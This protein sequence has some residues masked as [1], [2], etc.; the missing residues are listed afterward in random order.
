MANNTENIGGEKVM[1]NLPLNFPV[2]YLCAIKGRSALKQ[3]DIMN[4]LFRGNYS[5]DCIENVILESTGSGYISGRRKISVNTIVDLCRCDRSELERRFREIVPDFDD[6]VVNLKRLLLEIKPIGKT[7]TERLLGIAEI[8]GPCAFLIEVLLTAIKSPIQSF[9]SLSVEQRAMIQQGHFDLLLQRL[10]VSDAKPLGISG[11]SSPET[12]LVGNIEAPE[13]R[14][15]VRPEQ[16][17]PAMSSLIVSEFEGMPCDFEFRNRRINLP[18]DIEIVT[19]YVNAFLAG[20]P[21][22]V[23]QHPPV[24]KINDADFKVFL[25]KLSSPGIAYLY[26]ICGSQNEVV[27][28]LQMMPTLRGCKNVVLLMEID[29][30]TDMKYV[31]SLRQQIASACAV[32]TVVIYGVRVSAKLEDAVFIRLLHTD[33]RNRQP[34]RQSTYPGT[35]QYYEKKHYY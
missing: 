11:Q 13:G 27:H 24:I 25:D 30:E 17:G 9:P 1:F 19:C 10:E 26:E 21:D 5:C 6:S 18:E 16:D 31:Q 29:P 34:R 33:N 15:A 14:E 2:Y 8:S 3:H 28:T 32:D 23:N 22:A 20:I 35:P 12:P 4:I 7:E